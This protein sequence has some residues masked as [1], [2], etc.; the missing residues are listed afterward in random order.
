[1]SIRKFPQAYPFLYRFAAEYYAAMAVIHGDESRYD[2]IERR[3]TRLD[4]V[5]SIISSVYSEADIQDAEGW[6]KGRV[7][8]AGSSMK[9]L[10]SLHTSPGPAPKESPLIYSLMDLIRNRIPGIESENVPVKLP[11]TEGYKPMLLNWVHPGRW[12]QINL[13][14]RVISEALVTGV[15]TVDHRIML[16]VLFRGE[17]SSTWVTL[18]V[19]SYFVSAVGPTLTTPSDK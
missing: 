13:P 9:G 2:S 16:D 15:S 11:L 3:N 7:L 12:V 5:F 19:D 17:K 6:I 10:I 8:Q 1:M 4:E 18:N 14:T